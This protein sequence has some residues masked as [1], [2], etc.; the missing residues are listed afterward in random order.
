MDI[1]S[2]EYLLQ[3]ELLQDRVPPFPTREALE[4]MEQ[5][6]ARPP[7]RPRF[8]ADGL[9]GGSCGRRASPALDLRAGARMLCA[10][11]LVSAGRGLGAHNASSPAI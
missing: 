6:A 7:C 9:H 3:I 10:L 5:G 1:L 8:L 2:P 11:C 4:V